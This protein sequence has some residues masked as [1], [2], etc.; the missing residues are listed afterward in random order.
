MSGQVFTER[1]E[2]FDKRVVDGDT[3]DAEGEDGSTEDAEA[4]ARKRRV[5]AMRAHLEHEID[6]VGCFTH[7]KVLERSTS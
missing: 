3:E 5:L 7:A 6:S 2:A 1:D 4:E